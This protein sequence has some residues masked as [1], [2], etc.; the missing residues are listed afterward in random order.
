[1]TEQQV[2]SAEK[3]YSR[4]YLLMEMQDEVRGLLS[5]ELSSLAFE[6]VFSLR[7]AE[8]SLEEAY[9]AGE[10]FNLKSDDVIQI[11]RQLFAC[12]TI[13]LKDISG[14]GGHTTFKYRNPGA[15]F[16]TTGVHY[17][18]HRGIRQA[19]NIASV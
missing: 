19:A 3:R 18:L 6:I 9:R 1:M 5:D 16:S 2:L 7:K 15:V 13:G 14:V 10:E 12:G 11:L 4:D 8:F 17:I